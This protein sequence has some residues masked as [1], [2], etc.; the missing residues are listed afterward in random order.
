MD[1]RVGR[2]IILFRHQTIIL[3]PSFL[4]S[5]RPPNTAC[6]NSGPCP[7][8]VIEVYRWLGV[9]FLSHCHSVS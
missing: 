8:A 3:Y 9:R 7:H 1:G 4:N 5:K 6:P 2:S